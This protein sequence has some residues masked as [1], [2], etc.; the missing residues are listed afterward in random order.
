MKHLVREDG[1]TN[2]VI[3]P[4]AWCRAKTLSRE[5]PLRLVLIATAVLLVA[6]AVLLIH[7]PVFSASAGEQEYQIKSGDVIQVIIWNESEKPIEVTV[8]AD[9]KVSIPQVGILNVA[10]LTTEQLRARI[11]E[12]LK[13]TMTNPRVSVY[14]RQFAPDPAN[15]VYVLG[16]V[17]KPN[18][19]ELQ[20]GMR[21][22][23][24]L[25]LAGGPTPLA[26][27]SQ[28][29][30]FDP[31]SGNRT[32]NLKKILDTGDMSL[33]TALSPGAV[34]LI[35]ESKNEVTVVGF[36]T[37]PGSYRF[38]KG[39]RIADAVAAVGGPTQDADLRHVSITRKSGQTLAIDL[40]A[41]LREGKLSDN[42]ELEPGDV[43]LV[44]QARN[45]V[46]LTG[47]FQHPGTYVFKPGQK[48]L[49]AVSLG[50]GLTT[51]A[52]APQ[53][54]ITR[55]GKKIP[56]NLE[57]ITSGEDMASN[58][59]LQHGDVIT[60]PSG[61]KVVVFGEVAKPGV[62]SIKQGDK[63]LSVLTQAGLP[64]RD[65]N[66]AEAGIIR[67]GDGQSTSVVK[68]DL[69]K[70]L[71]KGDMSQDIPVQKGDIIFV[72]RR[73]TRVEVGSVLSAVATLRWILW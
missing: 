5:Q 11:V 15:R 70:L 67:S 54:Y 8:S 47:E 14:L 73:G 40:E 55:E 12:K 18:W 49:D 36:V 44:P 28:A 13:E 10:G 19:Y 63:L 59:P 68:A 34:L 24:A 1:T 30:L 38:Q 57:K 64:T 50:G 52:D 65:A 39:E 20:P 46:T 6:A 7:A 35:P 2:G 9:G 42:L 23:D 33:N 37:K 16:Q 27:L 48:V 26:D 58:I 45:E 17:V 21:L 56:I 51:F 62:Y 29:S 69:R 61:A 25:W 22:L 72:P 41:V 71:T 4:K 53:A 3:F 43:I 31:K 66:L 60:V 32:V